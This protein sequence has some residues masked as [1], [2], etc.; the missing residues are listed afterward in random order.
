[1]A[2]EVME[3]G[4]GYDFKADIWSL[5]IVAIEMVTGGAPYNKYP[6]LKGFKIWKF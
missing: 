1:M 2:P 5:G 3:Q 4:T 6:P